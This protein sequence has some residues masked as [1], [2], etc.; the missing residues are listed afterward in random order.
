MHIGTYLTQTET[1]IE[2][3]YSLKR[4]NFEHIIKNTY[5]F[6]SLIIGK[7]LNMYKYLIKAYCDSINKV[8]YLELNRVN[9]LTFSY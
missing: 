6:I 8:S 2:P 5:F 3:V 9:I 4:K 1:V 7:L